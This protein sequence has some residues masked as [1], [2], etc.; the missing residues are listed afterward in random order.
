MNEFPSEQAL[1]NVV[2]QIVDGTLCPGDLR[3][4][5]ACLER[6][7]NGWKRCTLAFVEA[8]C[9]RDA[10]RAL[11]TPSVSVPLR[12]ADS[13][14]LAQATLNR[15]RARWWQGAAAAGIVAASFVLGWLSHVTRPSESAGPRLPV[16][17]SP[18]LAD[19]AVHKSPSEP[20]IPASD[21][22]PR[23]ASASPRFAADRSP[24]D[25]REIVET[26]AQLQ[27]GP[28]GSGATVPILAGP[29]ING[30]WLTSQPPPLS[31]YEQVLLHRRGYQVDQTRRLLIGTL[32]DGRRVSV[33][34]D[35]VE[36]RFTGSNPL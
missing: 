26:V 14:R 17:S 24:P 13:M 1:D 19:G 33:P 27:I 22:P 32:D 28:E 6:E 35:Q 10:F 4:A 21:D 16:S 34:V 7:A 20:V 36:I 29:G 5:L 2:D 12:Q 3:L 23:P 30:E 9:W 15:P 25:P 18:N 31:E 11:E 8:Q